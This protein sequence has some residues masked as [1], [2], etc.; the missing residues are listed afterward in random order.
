MARAA[1]DTIRSCE[2]SFAAVLAGVTL[3]RMMSI[4]RQSGAFGRPGCP[5]AWRPAEAQ[6]ASRKPAAEH[7]AGLRLLRAGT[8]GLREDD[9]GHARLL[10]R[11][12]ARA[13]AHRDA[14]E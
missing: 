1:A 4:I 8:Q 6:A 7:V 9:P 13:P 5:Q 10:A 14:W 12:D 2:A 3:V 11:I